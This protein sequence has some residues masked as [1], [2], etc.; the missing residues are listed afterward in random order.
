MKERRD[1]QKKLGDIVRGSTDD[2]KK[3]W[4]TTEA[5]EGFT[6]LPPGTYRCLIASGEMFNHDSK[7]TPGF[8]VIFEVISGPYA[9]RKIWHDIWLTEKALGIAKAELAKLGIVQPDQL[10]RPLPVGLIADVKIVKRTDDG[11]EEWNRVKRFDLV[12]PEVPPADFAPTSAAREPGDD[13]PEEGTD[14]YLD[15]GGFDWSRGEQRAV[16]AHHGNGAARKG[17]Q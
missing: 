9:S 7:G 5:S 2:F 17:A 14:G 4:D 1:M 3:S 11:G 8:K 15:S 10:E 16:G 6:P 13:E 12:S